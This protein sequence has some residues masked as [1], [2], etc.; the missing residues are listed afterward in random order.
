[1]KRSLV[2]LN[3][4]MLIEES[5]CDKSKKTTI[6][7][8]LG[9]YKEN[10]EELDTNL[11]SDI[12]DY[13]GYL[14]SMNQWSTKRKKEFNV[15]EL[16]I[17]YTLY[18]IDLDGIEGQC[19]EC[20]MDKTLIIC[21]SLMDNLSRLAEQQ[22]NEEEK[23]PY[24]VVLFNRPIW[25]PKHI[26]WEN[27]YGFCHI[28]GLT[29]DDDLDSKVL[30]E[31]NLYLGYL[32]MIEELMLNDVTPSGYT[33]DVENDGVYWYDRGEKYI[34]VSEKIKKE[35]QLCRHKHNLKL[36][37]AVVRVPIEDLNEGTRDGFILSQKLYEQ[38]IEIVANTNDE[39]GCQN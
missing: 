14:A 5:A 34:C 22:K 1:M 9:P 20:G 18:L 30:Q 21:D 13:V 25:L 29:V 4:P 3:H 10:D 23:E 36:R 28:Y 27:E 12:D 24:N 7:G 2:K 6:Y 17:T 32:A 19:L 33:A 39:D 26:L 31:C 8:F 37:S 38:M 35:S 11:E 16:G 15:K